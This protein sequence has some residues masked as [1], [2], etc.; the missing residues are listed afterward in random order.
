MLTPVDLKPE[1]IWPPKPIKT[2]LYELIEVL[3][4]LVPPEEDQ[5]VVATV[6]YLLCTGRLTYPTEVAQVN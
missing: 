4:E 5:L 2:T 6:V 3:N 1:D